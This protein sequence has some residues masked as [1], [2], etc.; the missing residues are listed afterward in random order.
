MRKCLRSSICADFAVPVAGFL[1]GYSFGF[2]LFSMLEN[3]G[4]ELGEED[5]W[6]TLYNTWIYIRGTGWFGPSPPWKDMVD[7]ENPEPWLTGPVVPDDWI[8]ETY[9]QSQDGNGC[10]LYRHSGVPE[11]PY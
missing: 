7:K 11:W 6:H 5:W 9:Q 8:V 10:M 2:P 4:Y 3:P 1:Y